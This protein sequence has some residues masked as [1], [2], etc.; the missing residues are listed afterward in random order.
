MTWPEKMHT[1]KYPFDS[2]RWMGWFVLSS[3]LENGSELENVATKVEEALT[4]CKSCLN[5]RF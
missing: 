3:L 4:V 5:N 2:A 1:Q